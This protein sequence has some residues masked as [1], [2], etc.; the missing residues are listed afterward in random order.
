MAKPRCP[1]PEVWVITPGRLGRD[2][3][4]PVSPAH[5]RDHVR[6]GGHRMCGRAAAL[7][8][9]AGIGLA[10]GRFVGRRGLDDA[11]PR[12]NV[13]YGP[14]RLNTGERGFTSRAVPEVL[15]LS[16]SLATVASRPR[17]LERNYFMC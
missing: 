11:R 12:R 4:R 17:G 5:L 13:S 2:E 10:G 1:R 16:R 14:K 15:Y 8:R 7:G 6:G 3:R 9:P